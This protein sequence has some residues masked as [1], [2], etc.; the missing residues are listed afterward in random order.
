MRTGIYQRR[1]QV[2]TRFEQQ[3]LF[4]VLFNSYQAVNPLQKLPK[5]GPAN[6]KSTNEFPLNC[7]APMFCL[8]NCA[9]S[10][11]AVGTD[12]PSSL[13]GTGGAEPT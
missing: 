3:W 2:S 12:F 6:V 1:L 4:S 9:Q 13:E 11:R 7:D 5:K 10:T 8:Q